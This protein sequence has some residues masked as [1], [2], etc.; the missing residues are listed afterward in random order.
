VTCI[1]CREAVIPAFA[2][3]CIACGEPTCDDCVSAHARECHEECY[4]DTCMNR[5]CMAAESL[6]DSMEDR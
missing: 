2:C 5:R 4:C 3:Q 6:R 1:E